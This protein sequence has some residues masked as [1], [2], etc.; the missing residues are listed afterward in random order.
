MTGQNF[1]NSVMIDTD[2]YDNLTTDTTYRALVLDWANRVQKDISGKQDSF[3]WRWLEKTSTF[4]TVANQLS[5]DLP[6]DIDGY[7]ILSLKQTT[8]DLKLYFIPQEEFDRL[9]PDPTE[10]TGNPVCYT[11][12]ANAIRL[13]PTPSSAIQIT[14]RYVKTITALTDA[15]VSGDIPAK[16]DDVVL[17][18]ILAKAYKF[19][20]RLQ[21]SIDSFNKYIEG[22]ERMKVDNEMIIDNIDVANSHRVK[23]SVLNF[24][25]PAGQ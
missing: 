19:D 2:R 24:K 7:K 4:N 17:E 3:H 9:Y 23:R 20:K 6:S 10:H 5:Y 11:L 21:E 14:I 15:A 1:I 8:N 12:F 25:R 13:Y 22:V 16:W 18:G